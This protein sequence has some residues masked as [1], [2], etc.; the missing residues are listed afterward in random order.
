MEVPALLS[1]PDFRTQVSRESLVSSTSSKPQDDLIL[2]E[3]LAARMLKVVE[4]AAVS[5]EL[6]A[7]D[8]PADAFLVSHGYITEEQRQQLLDALSQRDV[9]C[10]DQTYFA[11]NTNPNSKPPSDRGEPEAPQ[12]SL[13][14]SGSIAR[15]ATSPSALPTALPSQLSIKKPSTASGEGASR[16]EWVEKFAQGGLGAVWRAR[17]TTIDRN[18][19]LKEILPKVQQNPAAVDQFLDEARITGQLQHPGVVPI[20]DIGTNV[21]GTPFYIM[22]FIDGRTLHDA[23]RS[24]HKDTKSKKERESSLPKLLNQF[25]HVCRT[26]HYAHDQGFIHRDLKPRN[27]MLGDYGETLVVDWGL[28]ISFDVQDQDT[29]DAAAP[30]GSSV[31]DGRSKS[32]SQGTRSSSQS[33][34]SGNKRLIRQA[35]R[36][37]GTPAYLAPEQARG[38]IHDMDPR[39]DIYSLGVVLYEILVGKPPFQGPD[40][41]TIIESVLAGEF[42]E[43][44]ATN[45]S[46]PRAL[47][48]VCL[49]AMSA[50]KSDR[51]QSA[52]EL[53]D[54]IERFLAGNRVLSHPETLGERIKRLISKNQKATFIALCSLLTLCLVIGFGAYQI[55]NARKSELAARVEAEAAHRAETLARQQEAAAK[56]DAVRNLRSALDAVDAWPLQ[57]SGDLEFYPGLSGKRR[58]FLAAAANYYTDLSRFESADILLQ[59]EAARALIR[60]GDSYQLLGNMDAAAPMFEKAVSWFR[61]QAATDPDRRDYQQELANALIGKAIVATSR[62][63]QHDAAQAAFEQATEILIGLATRDSKDL[64]IRTALARTC[65]GTAR[66]QLAQQNQHSAASAFED[67]RRRLADVVREPNV[68]SRH[69]ALYHSTLFELT[70]LYMDAGDFQAATETA[71][72]AIRS[73]DSAILKEP[74]RPDY[75]EGRM[76]AHILLG[77]VR[78]QLKQI[79]KALREY[80]AASDDYQSLVGALHRGEYHSENLVAAH[81]NRARILLNRGQVSDALQIVAAA[82]AELG[83]LIQ[84]HGQQ[85]RLLRLFAGASLVLGNAHV[86][87]RRLEVTEGREVDWLAAKKAYQDAC[88]VIEFLDKHAAATFEDAIRLGVAYRELSKIAAVEDAVPLAIH[89]CNSAIARLR[90]EQDSASPNDN[91]RVTLA[92]CHLLKAQLVGEEEVAKEVAK[93]SRLAIDLLNECT[94]DDGRLA[95]MLVF[96]SRALLTDTDQQTLDELTSCTNRPEGWLAI[97]ISNLRVGNETLFSSAIS[98][99]TKAIGYEDVSARLLSALALCQRNGVDGRSEVSALLR[100]AP[101]EQFGLLSPLWATARETLDATIATTPAEHSSESE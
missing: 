24:H 61:T 78:E 81:V 9:L 40:S 20:Y 49:K 25:I 10:P 41:Q 79:D 2:H 28:A 65:V 46:V 39:S 70:Y 30:A 84:L 50:E 38:H 94:T 35:G 101:T 72:D 62:A 64:E 93:E 13:T 97:A 48:S 68:P 7:I 54:E 21:D 96:A 53:A 88:L 59:G 26:M 63:E 74:A 27:I 16:Y 87:H 23:I 56:K 99:Y 75:Y 29:I 77:N 91:W 34:K 1:L 73:F 76:T 69:V 95:R 80:A 85:P 45:R 32:S 57:L 6:A 98:R 14:P 83:E 90:T 4:F 31:A 71:H 67:A 51:F 11:A 82:T 60:G 52:R 36:V 19:A 22:K 44:I 47:N 3:A 18:V 8:T 100:E 37:V 15:A 17:D 33:R 43:P 12:R 86:A 89:L 42:R 5:A 55:N 92:S 58:E 66:L